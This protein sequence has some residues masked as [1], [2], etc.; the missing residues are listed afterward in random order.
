MGKIVTK[1]DQ[2]GLTLPSPQIFPNS[3][4]VGVVQVDSL[5]FVAGHPP[6]ELEDVKTSGKIPTDLT[7]EEGYASARACAL[8]IL[9]TIREALGDLDRVKRAVKLMGFINSAPGFNRQFEVM[10]GAS[11]LYLSLFGPDA[12]SAR[13]A[14]G[15]SDL[16]RDI[17]VEIEGV[18]EIGT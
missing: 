13:A 14:I 9:V 10:D 5:L 3:N 4:R 18:F 16:A 7:I 6:A 8:N 12:V 17:P 11:D 1:L 15:A 2:L